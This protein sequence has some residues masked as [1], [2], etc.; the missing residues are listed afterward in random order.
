MTLADL[1]TKEGPMQELLEER[2][3]KLVLPHG[4]SDS[5]NQVG[6]NKCRGC[7]LRK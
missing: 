5:G 4:H 7:I 6:H 3:G 2:H 1:P